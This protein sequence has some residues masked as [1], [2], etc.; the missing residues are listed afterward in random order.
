[1]I[2]KMPKVL[3]YIEKLIVILI[4][5]MIVKQE[6]LIIRVIFGSDR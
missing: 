3:G 1:M 6:F 5:P 4:H 2:V